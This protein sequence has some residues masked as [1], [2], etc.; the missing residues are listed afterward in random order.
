MVFVDPFAR[1]DAESFALKLQLE[2]IEAQRERQT[3]KWIENNPP[4][5]VL[6]FDS[7]EAELKKAISLLEDL[8]FAHSVAKAVDSDGMAIEA[9]RVEETQCVQTANIPAAF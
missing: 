1:F 4:D 7:F 9:S 8:K 6:A 2:E 5:F 3:G